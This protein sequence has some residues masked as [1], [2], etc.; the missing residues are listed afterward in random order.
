MEAPDTSSSR[1]VRVGPG[2]FCAGGGGEGPA[3][4]IV[5]PTPTGK[6]LR[7]RIA[8]AHVRDIGMRF[9][10]H[11]IAETTAELD[12]ILRHLPTAQDTFDG[13]G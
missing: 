6:R 8:A 2:P 5:S 3:G 7:R 10:S 4:Q 1:N 13:L 9:G 11:L 12:A